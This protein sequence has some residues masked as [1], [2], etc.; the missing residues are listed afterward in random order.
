MDNNTERTDQFFKERLG[1]FEQKPDDQVWEKIASRLG[2]R[3]SKMPVYLFIRIAAGMTLLFSLG[4]GYYLVTRPHEQAI[5]SIISYRTGDKGIKDSIPVERT[6]KSSPDQPKRKRTEKSDRLQPVRKVYKGPEIVAMEGREEK[7]ADN[8]SDNNEKTKRNDRLHNSRETEILSLKSSK[9]LVLLPVYLPDQLDYPRIPRESHSIPESGYLLSSQEF[10]PAED[11]EIAG[12][13]QWALG[14]EVAPLYSYRTIASDY[15]NNNVMDAMNKS[16]EGMIAY[17]GG[18]R[19]SYAAGKRFSVQSGIY[20]SRYGQEKNNVEAYVANFSTNP[21]DMPF[22][23]YISIQNSTGTIQAGSN[24]KSGNNAVISTSM[25]SPADF[26]FNSGFPGINATSLTPVDGSNIS[27]TQYFDYLELP[28]TVKY[29]IVDRKFG[30]S[31]IGGLVTNFLVNNGLNLHQNGDTQHLGETS[32]INKVNYLGSIGV[33]FEYPLIKNVAFSL[34]PRFR[35]YI[36]PIDRSSQINV[37][38]YSFGI[39]AGISY[40]F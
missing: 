26:N 33:G 31:F 35:Y 3:S 40:G 25:N 9:E 17:A 28:L 14:G 29:K 16:E 8:V 39:F 30:F 6:R 23:T 34:E 22:A 21:S 18:I 1:N 12:P 4:L 5:P 32:G 15:L 24:E 37:H 13:N 11:Q 20:Y 36:N 10:A 2:P 7:S 19:V 38:P 27:A